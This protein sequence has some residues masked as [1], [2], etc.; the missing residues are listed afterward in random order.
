[1]KKVLMVLVLLCVVIVSCT[2]DAQK[3]A[4][5]EKGLDTALVKEIAK[6][7]STTDRPIKIDTVVSK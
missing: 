2:K 7:G 3:V 6:D 5:R 4:S 1:M